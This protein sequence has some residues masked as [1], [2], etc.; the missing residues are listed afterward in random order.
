ML[1]SLHKVHSRLLA[2]FRE[3]S[4]I[5]CCAVNVYARNHL[6]CSFHFMHSF[7]GCFTL[8]YFAL[9]CI[10]LFCFVFYYL[11][12]IL[13][14]TNCKV[15]FRVLGEC[16]NSCNAKPNILCIANIATALRYTTHIGCVIYVCM[17]ASI[18]VCFIIIFHL[19]FVVHSHFSRANAE[20]G[21][22]LALTQTHTCTLS[23]CMKPVMWQHHS[24]QLCASKMLHCHACV[25]CDISVLL[26]STNDVYICVPSSEVHL[27]G[28]TTTAFQMYSKYRFARGPNERIKKNDDSYTIKRETL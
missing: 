21:D 25:V 12:L 7:F 4:R 2:T 13:L 24:S 18:A 11:I 10:V 17:L 19:S 23:L 16:M 27:N 14:H 15:A 6:R 20:E 9:L 8:F 3:Y 1:N 5:L 26:G 28:D 22:A